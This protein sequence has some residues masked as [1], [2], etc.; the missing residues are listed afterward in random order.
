M[1]K[2]CKWRETIEG[3]IH[4]L[5]TS[6]EGEG[7]GGGVVSWWRDGGVWAEKE[8]LESVLQPATHTK[9]H[10]KWKGGARWGRGS[11]SGWVQRVVGRGVKRRDVVEVR[12]QWLVENLQATHGHPH[13][14]RERL[15]H[16]GVVQGQEY[17]H[18]W[19]QGGE[20]WATVILKE[21]LRLSKRKPGNIINFT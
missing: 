3:G 14:S 21:T 7:V 18:I 16:G 12:G 17:R 6:R 9:C 8:K 1:K 13:V 19:L 4:C 5:L 2:T 20:E 15:V 10:R 11:S